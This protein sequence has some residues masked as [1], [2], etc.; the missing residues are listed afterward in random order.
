MYFPI[1]L[2]GG[3][4]PRECLPRQ[5]GYKSLR[6]PLRNR[7]Y[8]SVGKRAEDERNV[9]KFREP[10]SLVRA[11][12][13]VGFSPYPLFQPFAAIIMAKMKERGR[14]KGKKG[15]T[16]YEEERPRSRE[17]QKKSWKP[18]NPGR[19]SRWPLFARQLEDRR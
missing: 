7:V 2:N 5:R 19:P 10:F 4:P 6:L 9:I 11:E 3:S 17:M 13:N 8:P 12:K 16:R 18:R 1:F 14:G 15:R